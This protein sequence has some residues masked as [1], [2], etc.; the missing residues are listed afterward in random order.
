MWVIHEINVVNIISK[1]NTPRLTRSTVLPTPAKYFLPDYV[2]NSAA[3]EKIRPHILV[4]K[5]LFK[6]TVSRDF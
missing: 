4:Y 6:G 1:K 3:S 5:G 2:K